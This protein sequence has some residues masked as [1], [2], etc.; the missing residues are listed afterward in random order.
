M[1]CCSVFMA[2]HEG[3]QNVTLIQ[4]PELCKF[5][6]HSGDGPHAR[7]LALLVE[8]V[9]VQRFRSSPAPFLQDCPCVPLHRL[10]DA[11]HEEALTLQREHPA[12]RE[13]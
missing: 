10:A 2:Y 3:Q 5:D 7:L 12:K 4:R 8:C 13:R 1:R 9:S 6:V 11:S